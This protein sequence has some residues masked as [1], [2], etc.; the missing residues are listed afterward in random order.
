[1]RIFG[2]VVGGSSLDTLSN[3]LNRSFVN[4]LL[5]M[6][7]PLLALVLTLLFCVAGR[8]TDRMV[9]GAIATGF[10]LQARTMGLALEQVLQESRN[11]LLVLAAG[12]LDQSSMVRRMKQRTRADPNRFR[13]VAY[14]GLRQEDCY[15]L[16]NCGGG[17]VVAIPSDV[18]LGAPMGPFHNLSTMQ[19]PGKVAISQPLE[20]T[21]S[22][23]PQENQVSSTS[24]HVIRLSTPIHDAEGHYRGILI[25][26]VDMAMLRDLV[27]VYAPPIAQRTEEG[28]EATARCFFFDR[29]GWMLF[30]S[31]NPATLRD[32]SIGLDAVRGG[33][34]GDFGRSGYAQA[35]RPGSEY[36]RYW[37]MVAEVQSGRQG[38]IAV[39][40]DAEGFWGDGPIHVEGVSYAPVAF[41]QDA[42]STPAVIGGI[43]ILDASLTASRTE[44]Q[45]LGLFVLGGLAGLLLA[46]ACLWW[47]GRRVDAQLLRIVAALQERQQRN[48]LEPLDVSGGVDGL[49]RLVVLV[50]ALLERLRTV[51]EDRLSREEM[52][53]AQSLREPVEDLPDPEDVPP[54]G[55]VGYSPAILALQEHIRK[56]AQS[57][58]DVLVIGETGTGKELVSEAV[59]RLSQRSGGPFITI[60]CGALDEGL[61]MDTLFGH[62]KGAFTEAK[63]PRKGAFLAAEGGTLMLDEVGNAAPKVQQA[64]LRTLSTRRVKPL[65]ADYDVPFDTRIIAA[66]NAELLGGSGGFREDLYYRLAVIT[67]RTPPLRDRKEDIPALLVH[68]LAEA[69]KSRMPGVRGAMPR[70]SRGAMEKLLAHDWPG[71]VREFQNILTS[72]FTF[73]EGEIIQAEDIRIDIGEQAAPVPETERPQAAAPPPPPRVQPE[74]SPD[75]LNARQRAMLDKLRER[76]S[77]SRQE[78]QDMAE[79]GISMRTA[80]YDLQALVRAGYVRKKGKGPALR[81]VVVHRKSDDEYLYPPF[82][83]R[84]LL[85]STG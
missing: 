70:I 37:T 66:T 36:L 20:V 11:S 13:E 63:N 18:A 51:L 80:Q 62:V 57:T 69:L 68:C 35:F 59:H 58:A 72:A 31:E 32:V 64:L 74:E 19:Q 54:T 12:P 44:V 82:P 26:S 6:C 7:L 2:P 50:N 53:S 14:L 17:E 43:A 30:Q 49:G 25:L 5:L 33:F 83:D 76:G 65:G 24:F 21:Y 46:G 52:E 79:S 85:A 8:Q 4:R 3:I 15:V 22:L 28:R 9:S 56:A 75:G 71:N 38:R 23:V 27:S 60:N 67:L 47:T 73:C 16:L 41:A 39:G 34:R 42:E 40:S 55:L 48:G 45:M 61:L 78:Y 77:V 29:D 81:Y 84:T 10:N 1:M